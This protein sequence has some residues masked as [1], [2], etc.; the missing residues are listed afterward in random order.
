MHRAANTDDPEQLRNICTALDE[1][2]KELPVVVSIH[3]R[4]RNALMKLEAQSGVA[5]SRL[6]LFDP[7]G[8][9]DMLSL[10]RHARAILTDS[11]GV[12]K[13]AYWLGVPCITL[14]DETEWTE[15]VAVGANTLAGADPA[16]IIRAASEQ[17]SSAQRPASARP[18][19]YGDGHAA[20][21]ILRVVCNA[22]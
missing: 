5:V 18:A 12:Q 15:T 19:V 4:T 14:R 16:R 11:G 7:L 3:P 10:M 21:R 13:E 2:A 6:R 17:E 8:Y 1:L 9:F 20:E 22:F